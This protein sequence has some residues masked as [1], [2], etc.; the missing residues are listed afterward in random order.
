MKLCQPK[1]KM[2]KIIEFFSTHLKM[3]SCCIQNRRQ[4]VHRNCSLRL[5]YSFNG[6]DHISMKKVIFYNIS[7]WRRKTWTAFQHY[8]WY[9]TLFLQTNNEIQLYLVHTRCYTKL[10]CM[11]MIMKKKT[12]YLLITCDTSHQF[13]QLA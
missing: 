8:S 4:L 5:F 3:K 7:D 2:Y 11:S 6:F 10:W 12:F 9:F 13:I 1:Q